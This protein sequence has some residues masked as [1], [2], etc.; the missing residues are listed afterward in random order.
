MANFIILG[1]SSRNPI[2]SGFSNNTESKMGF[3]GG[4]KKEGENSDSD[5]FYG[6]KSSYLHRSQSDGGGVC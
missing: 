3:F 4:M 1:G 2:G 6:G 5:F